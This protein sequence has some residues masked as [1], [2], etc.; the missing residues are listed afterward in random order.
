MRAQKGSLIKQEESKEQPASHSEE[1]KQGGQGCQG[2][3]R[4]ELP[5]VSPLVRLHQELAHRRQQEEEAKQQLVTE[6]AI[7]DP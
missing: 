5:C 2:E 1:S 7:L 3:E 6:S 4:K